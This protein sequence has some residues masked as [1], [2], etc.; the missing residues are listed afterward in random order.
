M[1]HTRKIL[2][3]ASF[4]LTGLSHT[5]FAQASIDT[6]RMPRDSAEEIFQ[7]FIKERIISNDSDY[8]QYYLLE[9]KPV[10]ENPWVWYYKSSLTK[11]QFDSMKVATV[12]MSMTELKTAYEKFFKSG[13]DPHYKETV[14]RMFKSN[15]LMRSMLS[16]HPVLVRLPHDLFTRLLKHANAVLDTTFHTKRW[17]Q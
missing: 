2:L 5:L 14:S 8:I 10:E 3:I 16:K 7:S 12:G 15:A 6:S 11:V 13:G 9:F 17:D 4:F 1:I